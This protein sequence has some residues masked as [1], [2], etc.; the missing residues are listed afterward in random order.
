MFLNQNIIWQPTFLDALIQF[1]S[2]KLYTAHLYGEISCLVSQELKE[3]IIEKIAHKQYI[4]AKFYIN[5]SA[6]LQL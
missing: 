3:A 1:K 5:Y 4:V 2:I 6:I